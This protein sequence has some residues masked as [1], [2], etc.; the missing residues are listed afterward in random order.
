MFIKLSDSS[1]PWYIHTIKAANPEISFPEPFE[2]PADYAPVFHSPLPVYDEATQRL[3]EGQ[4]A[5]VNG[6][7]MQQWNVVNLT[8][9]E[10]DA[11][12][13]EETVV[14]LEVTMRQARLALLADG[15]L[16]DVQSVIDSLSSPQRE[17]AQIEWDYSSTVKRSNRFVALIGQALGYSEEDLDNLFIDAAKL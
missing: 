15:K 6:N 9:E 5:L 1:Y 10:I 2:L 3:E 7:W 4:P 14:P 8:Q 12:I 16:G 13:A 11:K 17:M